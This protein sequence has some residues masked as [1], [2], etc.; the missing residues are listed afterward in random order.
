[1]LLRAV[2]TRE[3]LHGESGTKPDPMYRESSMKNEDEDE[4]ERLLELYA[5]GVLRC[6][7]ANAGALA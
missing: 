3:L 5:N 2:F 7:I 4:K 1:M 6:R